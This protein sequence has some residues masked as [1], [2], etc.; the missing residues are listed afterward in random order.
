MSPEAVAQSL[1]RNLRRRRLER[2]MSVSELARVSGVSKATI[3]GVERG[4]ANPAVDTVWAL[5]NALNMPFGALFDDDARDLVELRRIK[6]AQVVSRARGFVGRRL[7]AL[8]RRG[9]LEVYV[10]DVAAG[11]RRNA[12]PHP[13][14]VIE[15]VIVIE[16]RAEVGPDDE[17]AV[18][19]VGDSL[20]FPADR[21]HHYRGLE[22]SR[23]LSVTD[24]PV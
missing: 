20:T 23:L 2:T 24:Y 10:L 21:P 4:V 17:P 3:S 22:R 13:P 1:A 12:A 19:S 6:D 11:A 5:A 15:H 16:G 8:Q 9:D 7:L 18:L 14:G